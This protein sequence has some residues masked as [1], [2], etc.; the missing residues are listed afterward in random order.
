VIVDLWDAG[1]MPH[2]RD[3]DSATPYLEVLLPPAEHATGGAALILPGGAYTF[4]SEK[5]GVQYARWLATEGIAGI[6]VNFRLGSAGHRYPALLADAWQALDQVRAHAEAWN[7]APDRIAVMGSSAGAHLATMMLTGM[8]PDDRPRQRPALG[9]L[10]YPVVSMTDPLAHAETRENFL[11]DLS[12]DPQAQARFSAELRV[13]G[14]VP[15][16]FLW[17]TLDDKEVTAANALTF[18]GALQAAEIPYELH[19]YESGPHALG[20]AR[21][22]GLHWT[23]DCARWL[24]SHEF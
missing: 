9:V 17:H 13:D 20:L 21:N 6:V 10:C 23:A 12:A 15:P 4:L 8:L 18:A 16:C 5:S 22:A 19:V 24:H 7:I 11:G 1:T 2:A 14:Q 3:D